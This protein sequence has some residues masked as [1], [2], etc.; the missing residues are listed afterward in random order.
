[1]SVACSFVRL[2]YAVLC[3]WGQQVSSHSRFFLLLFL[4]LCS[5][6][7]YTNLLNLIANQWPAYLA[8]CFTSACILYITIIVYCC[9]FKWTFLFSVKVD[10]V[11]LSLLGIF[12]SEQLQPLQFFFFT[13]K[14]TSVCVS[15]WLLNVQKGQKLVVWISWTKVVIE[16]TPAIQRLIHYLAMLAELLASLN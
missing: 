6:D 16:V 4:F 8:V 10:I 12:M 14:S 15:F 11:K 1:M 2:S 3:Y 9:H 7:A 5:H 13:N